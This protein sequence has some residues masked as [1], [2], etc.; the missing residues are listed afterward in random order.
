MGNLMAEVNVLG[1]KRFKKDL[2][3]CMIHYNESDHGDS[4]SIVNPVD[5]SDIDRTMGESLTGASS[6]GASSTSASSSP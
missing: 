6:T 3:K 2:K 1:K 4:S 5:A